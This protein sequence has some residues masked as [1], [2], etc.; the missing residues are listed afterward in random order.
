M[1]YARPEVDLRICI[2]TSVP[3]DSDS[4][5]LQ[6]HFE[7]V[8]RVDIVTDINDKILIIHIKYFWAPIKARLK[9]VEFIKFN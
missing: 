7:Q 3:A 6:I 9:V 8:S 4:G 2:L 5:C 1:W